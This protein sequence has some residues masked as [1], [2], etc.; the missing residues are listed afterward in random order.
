[1]HPHVLTLPFAIT[2]VAV[3]YFFFLRLKEFTA[4]E[5]LLFDTK[6]FYQRRIIYGLRFSA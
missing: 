3:C 6:L 4:T 1:M 2:A 5:R